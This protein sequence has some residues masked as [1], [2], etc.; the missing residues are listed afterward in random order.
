MPLWL[1]QILV[2]GIA[3]YRFNNALK[4]MRSKPLF[5]KEVYAPWIDESRIDSARKLYFAHELSL[6]VFLVIF[7]LIT[8]LPALKSFLIYVL[9]TFMLTWFC[10]Y[11][12]WVYH[13]SDRKN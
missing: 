13:F 11:L 12:W 9:L 1:I 8:Q 4:Y 5:L 2:I 7:P 6:L 10:L 3:I